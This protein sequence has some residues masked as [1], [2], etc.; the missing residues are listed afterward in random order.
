MLRIEDR[1]DR[2]CLVTSRGE[3]YARFVVNATESYTPRLH[4]RMHDVIQPIQSQAASGIGGPDAVNSQVGISGAWFFCHRRGDR[5]IFGSDATR[6]PDREAG[7][8]Q[9]S[10]FLTKF[11]LGELERYFGPF[12]ARV[13]NE[14]SGTVGYTPDEY[15][16]IGLMDGKRQY[17]IAGM[18]GSG[19]GVAFNAARCICNRILGADVDDDYPP[20]YFSP[21][22][23]LDTQHHVWP[24]IDDDSDTSNG[25]VRRGPHF[26]SEGTA[27]QRGSMRPQSS[28]L[29][30]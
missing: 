15:P 4:P 20:A 8:H 19:T 5:I 23:L 27:R 16:I 29:A 2:Y 22:R 25:V 30:D 26:L 9:P 14:W 6:V 18:A 28:S 7:R 13:T 10:R 21:T 17:I 12:R 24:E 1:G 3:I 11:L